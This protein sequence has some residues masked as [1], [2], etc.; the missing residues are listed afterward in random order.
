MGACYESVDW[1]S[2]KEKIYGTERA[3]YKVKISVKIKSQGEIRTTVKMSSMMAVPSLTVGKDYMQYKT[4]VKL[5]Q[6]VTQIKPGKQGAWLALSLPE[7][8]P[9]DLRRTV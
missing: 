6:A 9:D 1:E 5:W 3:Q 4:E 8:H 7:D 2:P